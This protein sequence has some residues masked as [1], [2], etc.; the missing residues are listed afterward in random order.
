MRRASLVLFTVAGSLF[1]L[2]AS[3]GQSTDSKRSAYLRVLL[4]QDDAIVAIDSH[5]TKQKGDQRLYVSPPLDPAKQYTYTVTATWEPN[6]YT[7]VMRTRVVDVKA[8]QQIEIDLRKA[9][10]KYPDKFL[11]RFVPTPEDVVEAMCELAEVGKN[12]VVFD[13]GCGDGRIVINAVKDFKAKRGVGVDI[14]KELV[15]L[16]RKYAKEAKV[17]DKV[18]FRTQDVL[19]LKDLGEASVVMMYMGEDV[20]LRM[21]PILKSTLKPGSRIV[22]HDFKIGDWKADKTVTFFD[23]SG[24][25]HILYLWRIR[26]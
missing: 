21:M 12:D 9:D 5:P 20:N 24:E 2:N 10:D 25:E 26:K 22:S 3:Q 23:D 18:E 13:L 8:G 17:S 1:L 16:S 15:E 14:N 6:N 4:P 11:I 7:K 19:T